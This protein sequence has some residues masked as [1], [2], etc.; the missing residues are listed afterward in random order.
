VH[1]GD[2]VISGDAKVW[3]REAKEESPMNT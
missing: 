2:S 1:T 3:K